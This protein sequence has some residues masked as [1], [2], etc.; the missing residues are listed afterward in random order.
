MS[1]DKTPLQRAIKEA[2]EKHPTLD[3]KE[4]AQIAFESRY[5]DEKYEGTNP[6][7]A[8]V[9]Q[10]RRRIEIAGE[11]PEFIVE[12]P[13]E[14]EIEYEFEEPEE[15]EIPF[16]EEFEP[17]IEEPY[18][19]EVEPIEGFTRDDTD[20]VLCFTFDKIA[21]WTG[22]DG[23]RFKTDE[24]GRLIDKNERRFAGLTHRMAEKYLP[25]ILEQY[26]M[27]FMFC[28]T[29]IMLVGSKAKGYMDWR[30]RR[31]P[32]LKDVESTIIEKP[33]SESRE[34]SEIPDTETEETPTE[35]ESLPY[36]AKAKGE[37]EF[38]KRIRR[39]TP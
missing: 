19:V 37:E 36:G 2:I 38:T 12:P 39:Q 1:I 11:P 13:E 20:F 8:Y 34:A 9:A 32:V 29:G 31:E 15:P 21:D 7:H 28:Y 6:T 14:P 24:Q 10:Q 3:D 35:D 4:I 33:P 16:A 22:Y 25:D 23:W 26:F 17:E 5:P 27:E 30:K 18:P